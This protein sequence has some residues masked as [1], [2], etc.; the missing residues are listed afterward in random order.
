MSDDATISFSVKVK[1]R[2][3]EPGETA[4]VYCQAV[5]RA[6]CAELP[7]RLEAVLTSALLSYEAGELVARPSSPGMVV[8]ELSSGATFVDGG[9]AT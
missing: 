3:P 2:L 7:D 9:E 6:M 8:L 1:F 5:A 4:S